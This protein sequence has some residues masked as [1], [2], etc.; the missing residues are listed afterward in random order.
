ML[1]NSAARLCACMVLVLAASQA[2]AQMDEMQ[3]EF[4][5]LDAE[6]E[7]KMRQ[8][9]DQA[10]PEGLSQAALAQLYFDRD[11]AFQTLGEPTRREK[12]LR[13]AVSAVQNPGFKRNLAA[14]LI[15]KGAFDEANTL[16]RQALQQGGPVEKAISAAT[17]ACHMYEQNR[18][19]DARSMAREADRRIVFAK[20]LA[21]EPS[22]QI[23]LLSAAARRDYCMA[24]LESRVGHFSQAIAFAKS[25]EQY[26]RTA[27]PMYE[28]A[29]NSLQK[30]GIVSNV[31]HALDTKLSIYLQ[32][33]R[34]QDAETTLQEYARHAHE[35][36]LPA[37]FR[38]VMFIS[39][40]R[41]RFAQREFAQ[42]EQ[43]LRKAD[44]LL[45]GMGLQPL[46]WHR[47]GFKADLLSTLIGQKKWSVALQELAEIDRISA[48]KPALQAATAY[49]QERGLIYLHGNRATESVQLFET[50][51]AQSRTLNGESHFMTAQNVGLHG[52]ALW[53][54]GTP[55]G[56]ARALPLLKAA[57]R[58]YMAPANADYADSVGIRREIRE[59]IFSAYLDAATSTSLEESVRAIGPADWARGGVT[60]DALN[61]A[62]VR[63][64]AS[65]PAL[66]DVVRREQDAKNEIAGL[67]R[68]LSGE[69][70]G[71]DSPLPQI[72]SQMRE[73]I[74][75]LEAERVKLQAEVKANFPEYD[76][77][78]HPTAP[79]ASDIARQLAPEQA[80]VL[81]LPSSDSVYVWAI[82]RDR[83]VGFVRANMT[84]LQIKRLVTQ[85]RKQ[86]D[87]GTE[88]N[89]GT[90]FDG[91][92]AFA[93]YDALL[94]PL[95]PVL[96]GKTQLVIAAG[97]ALSQLPFGLLHTKAGGGFDENAPWLIR[98]ASV[99]QVPSLASWIAIKS[100][101]RAASAS[102][103]FAGWGDP[104]FDLKLASAPPAAESGTKRN[105]VLSRSAVLS[106]PNNL[107]KAAPAASALQYAS[108]P[109]LPDTREELLAIAAT[110]KS[111]VAQDVFLGAQATR[112]SVLQASKGGQL[113]NK[114]VIAFATHGLMAGDLPGLNQPALA[115]AATGNEDNEPLGPLLTLEDVLTL[116]LNADWVVLSACNTAAE[117]GRGDEAMSGLARGFFYAGSRSLL[118]THWA[119]ESESAKML[120]T[121]TF[122]HYAANPKAPKAESLRQA[123]LQV[124]ALPQF[125]HPAF[126]APYALV[127]DGGR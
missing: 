37:R 55:D 98:T 101:S 59:I 70:G 92:S 126:W 28:S 113:L 125:R 71:N 18:D 112:S 117:D 15:N 1:T 54:T 20:N 66:A 45:S 118:V 114:R 83:P 38:S 100:L 25:G 97:G 77:L 119:V 127:G 106:D 7:Q 95:A 29:A 90:R 85:L 35:T 34:L 30:I 107:D 58:D 72:A 79:S 48:S 62:A 13:A 26:A 16:M 76:R 108:I 115:L 87:F 65:T 86:L 111:D 52:A 17:I 94:A 91:S 3:A 64:A 47:L 75:T 39:G 24:L 23:K 104:A 68:F 61:D 63:S 43:F 82:A 121:A 67:R 9:I 56:K 88:R 102:Q 122:A 27:M 69:I 36:Q 44:E 78:I 123:M 10:I 53:R 120:T 93:L 14:V 42:S 51:A 4:R 41:L 21:A 99:T 2:F 5:T 103:A 60:K 105:V 110:L 40:A 96:Q 19:D 50:A 32:A 73:R 116:K 22:Q 8:L 12:N 109:T 46:Q 57:V 84:E 6:Q 49:P 124:M 89:A 33:G 31:A 80:L 81:L 11:Y 74:G